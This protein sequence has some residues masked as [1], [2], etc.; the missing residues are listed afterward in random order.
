MAATDWPE[1]VVHEDFVHEILGHKSADP[2]ALAVEDVWRLENF[3]QLIERARASGRL[4]RILVKSPDTQEVIGRGYY[5]NELRQIIGLGR[6]TTLLVPEP[7]AD[8]HSGHGKGWV[9]AAK[10]IRRD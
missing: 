10:S 8:G 2:R 1:Q 7:A 5:R 3:K 6:R 4:R 9:P